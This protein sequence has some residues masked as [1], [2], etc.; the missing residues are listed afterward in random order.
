LGGISRRKPQKMI[1]HLR[2]SVVARRLVGVLRCASD[3]FHVSA[4]SLESKPR[5]PLRMHEVVSRRIDVHGQEPFGLKAGTGS[6]ALPMFAG[7]LA[8]RARLIRDVTR[9]RSSCPQPRTRRFR[10]VAGSFQSGRSLARRS[11]L[12][13]AHALS[14]GGRTDEKATPGTTLGCILPAC[15][16]LSTGKLIRT[17]T[18]LLCPNCLCGSLPKTVA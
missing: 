5:I 15:T 4:H 8:A 2:P 18:V 17:Q 16:K 14:F 10:R 6:N 13:A 9:E 7:R 1:R 12:T 3:T 11:A